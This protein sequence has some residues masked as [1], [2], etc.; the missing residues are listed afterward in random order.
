MNTQHSNEGG[1]MKR[2]EATHVR[3]VAL[4]IALFVPVGCGGFASLESVE[5]TRDQTKLAK[6]AVEAWEPHVREAAVEKL[7]DQNSLAKIAV[8]DDDSDVRHAAVEKLTNQATLAKIAI[9]DDDRR[10]RQAAVE[11]A[12]QPRDPGQSR[13]RGR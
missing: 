11:K 13:H 12:R 8:E 3:A 10:V 4:C 7:N 6:I 9:E 5:R 1:R 2:N